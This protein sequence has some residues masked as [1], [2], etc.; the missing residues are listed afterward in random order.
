MPLANREIKRKKSYF[1]FFY[2]KL[3]HVKSKRQNLDVLLEEFDADMT[4][5][6][7]SPGGSADLLAM[8]WLLAHIFND[9]VTS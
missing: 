9:G 2:R 3:L 5:K 6:N 1:Q 4:R 8:S 7:L